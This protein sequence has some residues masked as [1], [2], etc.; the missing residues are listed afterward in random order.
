MS[1]ASQLFNSILIIVQTLTVG[2]PE[3]LG[4]INLYP[5]LPLVSKKESWKQTSPVVGTL[6]E[7]SLFQRHSLS[8]FHSI[9]KRSII[10]Q[11][12]GLLWHCRLSV[13]MNPGLT[14]LLLL[15]LLLSTVRLHESEQTASG[16]PHG[17]KLPT[18]GCPGRPQAGQWYSGE[19]TWGFLHVL[20]PS[21]D[22]QARW[23]CLCL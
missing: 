23:K 4:N 14:S 18:F 20:M 2:Y 21:H 7:L 8:N 6:N 12:P 1:L 5:I 11:I 15:G 10:P 13:F 17:W 19:N 22:T 3:L 9:F 16:S